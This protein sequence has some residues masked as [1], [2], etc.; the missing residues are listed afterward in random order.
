M[1]ESRRL[2]NTF[3]KANPYSVRVE[4]DPQ[5]GDKSWIVNEGVKTPSLRLSAIVGDSIHNFRSSLDHLAY[6]LVIANGNTPSAITAFPICSDRS[7]WPRAQAKLKGMSDRV[8]AL[9][10]EQQPCFTTHRHR[11]RQFTWLEELDIV[12]KHRYIQLTQTATG[13]GFWSQALPFSAS[14]TTFI[15]NGAV[16]RDTVL[17]RVPESYSYVDFNSFIEIAFGQGTS[18]E[19]ELVYR[20]LF[21]FGFLVQ[22]TSRLFDRF[23]P[24]SITP[25]LHRFGI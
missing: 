12:D 4:I 2:I 13:G 9:I 17:A 8:K 19:G 14:S 21:G 11:K 20:T 5:N 23:F 15:F 7:K 22:H 1:K 6:Q 10:E 16:Q 25:G 18:A 24:V 3:C